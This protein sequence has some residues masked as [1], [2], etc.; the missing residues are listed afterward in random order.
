MEVTRLRG[1]KNIRVLLIEDCEDNRYLVNGVLE[2]T[3]IEMEEAHNCAEGVHKALC[4]PYD[5]VL[6]DMHMPVLDG[7]TA[8]AKL[9]QKGYR[10]PIVALVEPRSEGEKVQERLRECG[11]NAHLS[12]P[13]DFDL[14]LETIHHFSG[15]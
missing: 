11:C 14:L 8:V 2:K 10:K 3:N 9:R 5:V 13:L 7:Y 4:N 15:H 6:M 1:L 12:K